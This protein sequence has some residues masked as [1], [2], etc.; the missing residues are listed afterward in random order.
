MTYIPENTAQIS[1]MPFALPKEPLI[2]FLRFGKEK[3]NCKN[4]CGIDKVRDCT[5]V[6]GNCEIIKR[7]TAFVEC[8]IKLI[9]AEN[10]VQAFAILLLSAIFARTEKSEHIN[11]RAEEVP[12]TLIYAYSTDSVKSSHFAEEHTGS[13][14]KYGDYGGEYQALRNIS[15][16]GDYRR[17]Y[18]E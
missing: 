18:S 10:H 6:I 8:K 13:H 4:Y 16:I 17:G 3:S 14:R 5:R 7:C 2:S 9:A 12:V 15:G 1:L 11:V